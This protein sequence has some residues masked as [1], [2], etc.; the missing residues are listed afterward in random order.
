MADLLI[1]ELAAD[2]IRAVYPLMR[3]AIPELEL[4]RWL[5]F[6]RRTIATRRG[7]K[8]GIM[9]ARRSPQRFPCGAICYRTKS[10]LR[11]G[12]ILFA[13]HV[14]AV[15][16]IDS[17]SVLLA[18]IEAF[19]ALG[20]R[21]GCEALHSVAY[22][23]R[24]VGRLSAAGLQPMASVVGKMLT[25]GN[26]ASRPAFRVVATGLPDGHARPGNDQ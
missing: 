5:Q 25:Q 11:L 4:D 7:S 17:D 10:D 21:L 24:L 22:G 2:E 18:L 9:V 3:E 19:E 16:M 12:Q 6:A 14:V 15:D 1:S 26:E 20:R 23:N 13:D 8:S